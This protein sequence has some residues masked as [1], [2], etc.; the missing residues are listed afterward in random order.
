MNT[1][2]TAQTMNQLAEQVSFLAQNAR[3]PAGPKDTLL[4]WSKASFHPESSAF[5]PGHGYKTARCAG[6]AA[7]LTPVAASGSRAFCSALI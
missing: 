3:C 4:E 2:M 1:D 5:V 6:H 7:I